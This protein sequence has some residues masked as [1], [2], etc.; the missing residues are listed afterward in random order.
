MPDNFC[1]Y[2]VYFGI[3]VR[4]GKVRLVKY[5]NNHYLYL[6][7]RLSKKQKS[8]LHKLMVRDNNSV[9]KIEY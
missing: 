5:W 2:F 6:S 4:F 8:T 1:Y 3:V 9:H 7:K